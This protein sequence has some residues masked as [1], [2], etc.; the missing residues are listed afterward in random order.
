M[1]LQGHSSLW[2]LEAPGKT[3][4]LLLA[5]LNWG[6]FPYQHPQAPEQPRHS[7]GL[8]SV[9]PP[10]LEEA[11]CPGRGFEPSSDCCPPPEGHLAVIPQHHLLSLYTPKM[12]LFVSWVFPMAAPPAPPG[13]AATPQT[14]TDLS[15][16]LCAGAAHSLA[17]P[18]EQPAS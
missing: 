9:S 12:L 17:V 15:T 5:Q 6:Q 10:S 18:S 2:A 4:N 1:G 13:T 8:C 7:G 3:Q 14:H 11:G 16:L